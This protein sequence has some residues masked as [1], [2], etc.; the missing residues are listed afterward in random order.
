MTSKDQRSPQDAAEPSRRAEARGGGRRLPGLAD[1]LTR[2][3]GEVIAL[4]ASG[5]SNQEIAERSHVSINSIKSY[6]RS[7][8]R[9]MG[10][11]SRSQA[12]LWGVENGFVPEVI[13]LRPER[14]VDELRC[15]DE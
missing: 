11:A 1:G 14:T 6:I 4:I 3:E 13:L 2:R 10:V 5:L 9:K 8:Y 12:V 15:A 7:A